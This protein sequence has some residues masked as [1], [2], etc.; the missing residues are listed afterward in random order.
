MHSNDK[1]QLFTRAGLPMRVFLLNTVMLI[2]VGIWLTGFDKVNWSLYL[3]PG[4]FTLSSLFGICPGIN[5]W[6]IILGDKK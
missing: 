6:Q 3:I 5:L 2:M 4:V 1:V